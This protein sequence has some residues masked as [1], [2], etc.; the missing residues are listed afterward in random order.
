MPHEYKTVY[1]KWLCELIGRLTGKLGL[2]Q[3]EWLCELIDRLTVCRTGTR[4]LA[5]GVLTFL[6]LGFG[7][8]FGDG[9]GYLVAEIEGVENRAFFDV[10]G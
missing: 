9:F 7:G 4:A 8:E 3:L 2:G 1:N 5:L 6:F 10:V